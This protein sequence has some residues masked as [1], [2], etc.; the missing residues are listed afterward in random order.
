MAGE[1]E[2]VN[3]QLPFF[4]VQVKKTLADGK[5]R[6]TVY[7]KTTN[8]RHLLHFQSNHSVR[9]KRSCVRS[10]FQRVQSCCNDDDVEQE[11]ME[12]TEEIF[13]FFVSIAFLV[14]AYRD[15]VK[16]FE[17]YYSCQSRM[18]NGSEQQCP[19]PT[20]LNS[21]PLH[22]MADELEADPPARQLTRA[23]TRVLR[24][25]LLT[26]ETTLN[27]SLENLTTTNSTELPDCKPE[28][29]LLYLFLMFCTLWMF[30]SMLNFT[31]TPFLTARKRELIRDVALPSTV[32]VMSF[33]GSYVF[34]HIDC[35]FKQ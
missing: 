11:E 25:A 20:V 24:S 35:T 17:T 9:H 6:T 21:T 8:A 7:R 14:E 22:P 16:E 13:A 19:K 26:E 29:S 34:R 18:L 31:K 10:L 23:L 12:S 5:I 2:E 32:L 1:G 15:L 30:I 4:H 33:V 27:L 3:N 28:V